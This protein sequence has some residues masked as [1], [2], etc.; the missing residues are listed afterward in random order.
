MFLKGK[1]YRCGL[2]VKEWKLVGFYLTFLMIR[3]VKFVFID[4]IILGFEGLDVLII[5]EGIILL[6]V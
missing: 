6:G 5:K 3:L 4:F 2:G 1:I